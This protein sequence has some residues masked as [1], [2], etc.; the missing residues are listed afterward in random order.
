[1]GDGIDERDIGARLQ[2]QMMRRLDVGR[3]DE[4]NPAGIGDDQ[5]GSRAEALFK[6]RREDRVTIG[7]VGADDEDDIRLGDRFEILSACGGAEGF[8][9]A[10]AGRRM[11]DAGAGVD[12]VVAEGRADEFLDEEDFLVRAAR[13]GD[14]ADRVAAIVGLD[15]LELAGGAT[16]RFFPRDFTPWIGD[17]FADHRLG[18]AVLVAGIAPGETALDAGMAL[19]GLAVLVGNHADDLVALHFG[20]EGA[21]DAAI[22]AGCDFGMVGLTHLDDGLFHEGCR[23]A[24]LNAGAAGNAFGAKKIGRAGGDA[25]VKAATGNGER[26][27]ALHFLAG[28][29]AAVADDAF[30]GVIGEVGV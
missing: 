19:I 24:G 18:D 10:V 25:G 7:R 21:A 1:M 26:E 3:F 15:A 23:R 20:L 14:G 17:L 13:R 11:A 6:A 2:G 9:Q 27:G 22:G 28:A 29:D 16:D 30:R 12:I 8:R 5:L 4:I